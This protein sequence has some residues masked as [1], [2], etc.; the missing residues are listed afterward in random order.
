MTKQI[1]T[2]KDSATRPHAEHSPSS[3]KNYEACPS[4]KGRSGTNPIAE[5]GTRIH[6]AVEKEDPST[7][8]DEVERSLAE[9]CLAF[10]AHTRGNKGGSANHLASHQEIFLEMRLGD[11]STYG[12]SDL[13]DLYS[14]GSGV[15]YD[16]KT[17]YGKVEDAEINAQVQAYAY[18][19]FQAFPDLNELECYL[20]LPRRQEISHA[21]YRRSDMARIRLRLSTIIARAKLAQ[22]YSPTEG[23]CEYCAKQGSCKALAEKA[24]VIGQKAGFE[25]PD[26]ITTDGTPSDKGKLLKLANLLGDWSDATK[27]EILRQ[28]LEDGQEVTGYRLDQRRTPRSIDNALVGYDAV[29]DLVSVEEYLLAC[30]RVSLAELEKFVAE[31]APR[32]HKAEAKQHLEDVLKQSGALREEGV[33]HLLKPIK[34]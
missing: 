5:A 11:H 1:V 13:L 6:E 24:L 2:H 20:V 16:W 25:V 9:W 18:G 29:K 31:R 8:V 17:G 15:L 3:L 27:K 23:V 30:P 22:E 19:C 28:S 14:D 4:F 12:T 33:I 26:S 21:V 34:A 10:L 7:L 32:G